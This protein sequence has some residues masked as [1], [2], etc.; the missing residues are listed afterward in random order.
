[1]YLFGPWCK[2]PSGDNR[3]CA[4]MIMGTMT[5]RLLNH[6]TSATR[7]SLSRRCLHEYGGWRV[8][9]KGWRPYRGVM[10]LFG[11]WTATEGP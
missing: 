7:R 10:Q 1:M 6:S 11:P 8:D 2:Q 3:W 9:Q 4:D 5:C